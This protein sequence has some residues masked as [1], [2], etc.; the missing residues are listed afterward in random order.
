MCG[1]Y[2]FEFLH[3]LCQLYFI[4]LL[5]KSNKQVYIH[6]IQT[7]QEKNLLNMLKYI[8]S[9]K[10][11]AL[12]RKCSED[13]RIKQQCLIKIVKTAET[14]VNIVDLKKMHNLRDESSVLF[15]A[16]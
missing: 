14:E 10:I 9:Y 7:T 11:V 12:V 13:K 3:V 8:H 4:L 2:S 15:G 5:Q 6:T 16:K 1:I